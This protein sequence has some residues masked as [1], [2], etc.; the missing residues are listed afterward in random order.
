MWMVNPLWMFERRVQCPDQAVVTC[1]VS[2]L[3]HNLLSWLAA[4][5]IQRYIYPIEYN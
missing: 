5:D 1:V 2:S 4:Q 3:F